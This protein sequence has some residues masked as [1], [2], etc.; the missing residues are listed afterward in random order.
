MYSCS[1]CFVCI[2]LWSS[3][4]GS[5]QSTSSLGH[6]QRFHIFFPTQRAT[7]RHVFPLIV[8]NVGVPFFLGENEN[9]SQNLKVRPASENDPMIQSQWS[10]CFLTFELCWLSRDLGLGVLTPCT[11]SDH[12]S[13]LP[14]YASC[15]S[16]GLL[17]G[18]IAWF[19]WRYLLVSYVTK[20]ISRETLEI[21][22]ETSVCNSQLLFQTW[23]TSPALS[24]LIDI[25]PLR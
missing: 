23:S 3:R 12:F 24:C 11:F 18:L 21:Y 17:S 15:P 10:L 9:L 13:F 8:F 20:D 1:N 4:L 14:E 7:T 16:I 19:T 5:V 22:R 25:W 6:G 2:H